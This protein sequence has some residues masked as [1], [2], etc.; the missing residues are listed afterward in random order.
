[1]SQ[2]QFTDVR[3]A[4]TPPSMNHPIIKSAISLPT[5]N[6][7]SQGYGGLNAVVKQ[8]WAS[9]K[10]D[11]IK[12]WIWTKK[13][14]ILKEGT[15][16]L[17]KNESSASISSQIPLREVTNVQRLETKGYCFE[18]LRDIS[19]SNVTKSYFISLK[20]D[21]EL[22]SWM[23][24]IYTRCPLMGVSNPTN[25]T[26]KVHVGFDPASGGF[27][28]LP[29]EWSKLLKT[30]AIT[31]EDYAQNPQAVIEVLEFYSDIRK[32]EEKEAAY[33]Q[34]F[35]ASQSQTAQ[36][37]VT[38]TSGSNKEKLHGNG[39]GNHGTQHYPTSQMQGLHVQQREQTNDGTNIVASRR[40]PA[41]PRSDNHV[42]KQQT[43]SKINS[44]RQPPAVDARAAAGA[45]M[46]G[47]HANDNSQN[48]NPHQRPTQAVPELPSAVRQAP[49]APRTPAAITGP[50]K[51]LQLASKKTNHAEIE[52][53]KKVD[54]P[55]GTGLPKASPAVQ[56]IAKSEE[57]RISGMSESQIMEK[58]KSVVSPG[59]PNML[60][61]KMKKV[62]QGASGS[63]Y[64]AKSI[65]S[66]N[67]NYKVA[68]KQ[69]DLAH[70]PRKELIVNEILVM[71]E[72]SHPNIVNFLDSFLRGPGELWVIMEYM[73]GGALT[74]VI[75]N[76]RLTEP[77]IALICRE[78]CQ[79]LAHLHS[80]SI[81][82][83]DIKSDNVL[84]DA[85]GNV[86]ITDF[87]FCAKLTEAKS[88]RATMV[89]TPYWM[90]PEVVKQKQYGEKVD[91][92]SLGIMAIEM[93]E[94][95]P[96]YLDEEPLKALYLIATHGTPKLKN[97]EKLSQEL[98]TFLGVCLCV[99][100]H[101]RSGAQEL[102]DCTFF[103]QSC[104]LSDLAPLLAFK[105]AS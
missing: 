33:K 89:G 12:S 9:V 81:I 104:Q 71:K 28:G 35:G 60:Y 70:Q 1:M 79:G 93:I 16:N 25:F 47:T 13:Y 20:S 96:P 78:T 100:V 74:D 68:I 14:M 46:R 90:A 55:S 95:E 97:P 85:R 82:H 42:I 63:V 44:A 76:N 61:Q 54:M 10:E 18:I 52:A 22:Y 86:K 64:V 92:W 77:Q 19:S 11:G 31:R 103:K 94:N 5:S 27:T 15:L 17:M 23:D 67:A 37:G 101:A 26:H 50:T 43:P 29:E 2:L 36:A 88:K 83:R 32:K 48:Y 34:R 98:R 51:P 73:E 75:D 80:Q 4:P 3:K 56:K 57:K 99:Q 38:L 62:G 66:K 45:A 91:V 6:P 59:D 102:L 40:A 7:I 87:G 21:A 105:T 41:P 84:L 58:L 49:Q 69:M 30:S 72:S 24:D 53:K 8:G 65:L 39:Y